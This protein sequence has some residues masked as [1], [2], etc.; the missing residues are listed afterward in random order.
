MLLLT[1]RALS[2]GVNADPTRRIQHFYADTAS[3]YTA[4]DLYTI[5]LTGSSL[6]R[7]ARIIG[8]LPTWLQFGATEGTSVYVLS[9][10]V[11]SATP[12]TAIISL[13]Y[14][15]VT[16]ERGLLTLT[17]EAL[18]DAYLVLISQSVNV[19][20]RGVVADQ[21][22]ASLGVQDPRNF[23]V[24]GDYALLAADGGVLPT[25]LMAQVKLVD[26][27]TISW[28]SGGGSGPATITLGVQATGADSASTKSPVAAINF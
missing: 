24:A 16:G 3:N 15:D 4:G 22:I 8:S 5:S 20:S 9:L 26:S 6:D 12:R 28:V 21:V 14:G 1:V 2:F 13:T 17:V 18:E 23:G 7:Y 27:T 10:Q 25:D 19:V 11:A